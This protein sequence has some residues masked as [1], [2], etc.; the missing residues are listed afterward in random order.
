MDDLHEVSNFN[1][2]RLKLQPLHFVTT[3]HIVFIVSYGIVISLW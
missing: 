1:G 2:F 3:L